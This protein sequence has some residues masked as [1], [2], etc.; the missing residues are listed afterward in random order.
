MGTGM[1]LLTRFS[2]PQQH[3]TVWHLLSLTAAKTAA[4]NV[5]AP[6]RIARISAVLVTS[7]DIFF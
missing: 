3:D 4:T 5:V 6:P 7:V 2:A 1:G